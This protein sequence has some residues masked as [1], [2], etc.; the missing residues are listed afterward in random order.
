[1][2]SRNLTQLTDFYQLT[3]MQGYFFAKDVNETVIF[4][5][6]YR[7][8][9]DDNGYAIAAG[10]EQVIEYIKNLHF[11]SDDIEYLRGTGYFREEFLEYLATFRFTGDIYALPEE[12]L[13][14][15]VSRS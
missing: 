5:A 6:F 12:P 1:M 9:P 10:L 8:N 14:S 7:S 15:R 11:T 4:D 3:M 2:T 13:C